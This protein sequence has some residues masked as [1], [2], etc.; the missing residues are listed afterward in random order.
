MPLSSPRVAISAPLLHGAGGYRSAG[1]H[2]YIHQTLR[3]LP[4]AAPDLRFTLLTEHPPADLPPAVQVQPPGWSTDRPLTRILWEQ[5]ALPWATRRMRASALHATAFVAPWWRTCPTVLTIYDLSFAL[6]PRMFR[7]FNQTYLRL[8][9]RVSARRARHIVV[10]SDCTRR[11]V[12]RLYGTPA[13][14]ISVAYPGVD[15]TLGPRPPDQRAA[16]RRAHHLPDRFVLYLGT[17]EPRKN[18][19][20]LVLAFAELKRHHAEAA[21][22]LAGAPG[23]LN[24]DLLTAIETSGAKDSIHLPGFVP[25]EEKASWYAAAT[26]FA[27]PSWYEG[28]GMPPL[29]AL[30]CGTPV[31]ASDSSAL[32]E[33]V[34]E[35]GWLVPPDDVAGWAEALRRAWNLPDRDTWTDRGVRQ[36]QKFTWPAA[37]RGIVQ[38]YRQAIARPF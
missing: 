1:I 37:A 27:F 12:Q 33:V 30:A 29:E 13:D 28:F 15:E 9:T 19:V 11:D 20:T 36:A 16:F 3:H 14:R 7:G 22:V 25:P 8:G 4:E 35:A 6:F 5:S 32:P 26:V 31:I 34:G 18:L 17:L 23:W 24:D 21:L 38:A 10:I 2:T